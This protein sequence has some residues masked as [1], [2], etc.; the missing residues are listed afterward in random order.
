MKSIES[1]KTS[2]AGNNAILWWLHYLATPMYLKKWSCYYYF[3]YYYY[4][5]Y[6]YYFCWSH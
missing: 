6:Y 4:Y 3:Y 2:L 5:F 1:M